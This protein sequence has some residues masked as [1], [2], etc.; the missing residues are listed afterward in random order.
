M[1]WGVGVAGGASAELQDC[2]LGLSVQG[3]AC[4]ASNA[5][6][7]VVL[8]ASRIEGCATAAGGK[9]RAAPLT[10][11]CGASLVLEGCAV[12][13]GEVA[14]AALAQGPGEGARGLGSFSGGLGCS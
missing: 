9:G 8:R 6:T 3:S 2:S 14:S 11:D 7:R 12:D 5:G 1:V 13:V 10:A 4:L